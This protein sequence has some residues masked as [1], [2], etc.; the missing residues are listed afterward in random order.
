M[1]ERLTRGWGLLSSVR[2]VRRGLGAE[3]RAGLEAGG[4]LEVGLHDNCSVAQTGPETREET[5]EK[6]RPDTPRTAPAVPKETRTNTA[7]RYGRYGAPSLPDA[8]KLSLIRSN[9]DCNTPLP[10]GVTLSLYS[11]NYCIRIAPQ[12]RLITVLG[13]LLSYDTLRHHTQ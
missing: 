8:N 6:R 10:R 3:G 5:R 13:A 2:R 9:R 7:A 11:S 4:G 12:L 1:R